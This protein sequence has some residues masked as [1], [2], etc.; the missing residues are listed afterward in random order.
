MQSVPHA[1]SLGLEITFVV[2]V[3]CYFDSYVFYN[4]QAVCFQSYTFHGIVGKQSHL[5][6]AEV[7]EH[8]CAAAVVA[9]VW[10]EAKVGIG[11]Y[12]VVSFFL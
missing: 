3:W 8:L 1:V 6:Y 11:V 5:V 7:A 9:L 2:L 4:F 10:L 12:G